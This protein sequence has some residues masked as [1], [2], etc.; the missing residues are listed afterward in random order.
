MRMF[1]YSMALYIDT[2]AF[3][4][5]TNHVTGEAWTPLQFFIVYQ[6]WTLLLIAASLILIRI[7]TSHNK[8]LNTGV[9]LWMSGV[10]SAM[11]LLSILVLLILHGAVFKG[12][13]IYPSVAAVTDFQKGISEFSI[14]LKE[15]PN[16]E[17]VSLF[18][19]STIKL[20][21]RTR[22]ISSLD[23]TILNIIQVIKY[24]NYLTL[25]IYS[26]DNVESFWTSR[27]LRS[28]KEQ[29]TNTPKYNTKQVTVASLGWIFVLLA[30]FHLLSLSSFLCEFLV[31]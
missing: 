26:D 24:I 10:V 9:G 21:L 25:S 15:L 5:A 4:E 8:R 16:D 11:F 29:S 17:L 23:S 31:F 13:T 22:E 14:C 28:I 18:C 27:L 20:I 6:P 1:H 12:N 30:S 3:Y 7:I 19:F 2:Y